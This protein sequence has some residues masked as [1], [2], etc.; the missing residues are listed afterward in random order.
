[1]INMKMSAK[2]ASEY[3]TAVSAGDEPAYP[4]GLS[5]SLK[6]ESLQKLGI[7]APPV[8]GTQ[9]RI[10][11]LVEVT[12]SSVEQQQ[13]GDKQTRCEMQITDME[14]EKP[15]TRDAASVLYGA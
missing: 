15:D 14:I 5:I 13:D 2:A 6:D 7:T 8:V 12:S 10:I 3:S 4:Y 9:M 11:C 1:M